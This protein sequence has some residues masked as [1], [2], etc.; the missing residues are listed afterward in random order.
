MKILLLGATG[1]SGQELLK[2]AIEKGY[3]VSVLV[4]DPAKLKPTTESINIIKGDVSDV[5]LLREAASGCEVVISALGTGKSLKS[6]GLITMAVSNLIPVMKEK[7]ISRLIMISAFGVGETFK[8]AN[9]IQRLIFKT[10]L[11]NIYADKKRGDELVRNSGLEWTLVY[12]T[13]LTNKTYSGK[14]TTG[15]KLKM[16]GMPKIARADLAEFMINEIKD[17]NYVRKSPIIMN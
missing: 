6:N 3:E 10:F 9:F 16:K 5:Q 17:R 2:K 7:N 14:Y 8:Q 11:R 15:E 12:P 1:P 4:R 13:L